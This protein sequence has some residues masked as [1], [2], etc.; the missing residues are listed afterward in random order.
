[1][2]GIQNALR[3][4]D[5]FFD[6]VI[7]MCVPILMK[8]LFNWLGNMEDVTSWRIWTWFS[9]NTECV[10]DERFISHSTTTN[11][12]GYRSTM[13]DEDTQNSI[14]LKAIK[15]YLDQVVRLDLTTAH[16]DL[17]PGTGE[18][19]HSD[20]CYYDSDDSEDDASYGSERTLAGQL[21]RYKVIKRLPMNEWYYIGN[22]A[23]GKVNLRI[24]QQHHKE[25]NDGSDNNNSNT[26]TKNVKSTT[27]HLFSDKR[28]SVDKFVD[29]AYR[30][31]LNELRKMDD[32]SRYYYDMQVP[33]IKIGKDKNDDSMERTTYKQ[34]KLSDEKSFESLFFREKKSLLE[35]VD[36][37][38]AKT[39]KYSIKGYPHKIGFLLY[40]PAGTGKTSLIKALAEYTGRSIVNVP[41]TRVT[42]NAELMSVFFDRRYNVQGSNVPVKL[43]FKDVIF[44]MEDCDAASKVVK[45]REGVMEADTSSFIS[46]CI[47]L[48][49]P[50]SLLR[51]FLESE[52]SECQDIVDILLSKSRRLKHEAETLRPQI[53]N[54]IARRLN[55]HGALG[56]ADEASSDPLIAQAYDDAIS[57]VGDR[58]EHH[59]KLDE[60]LVSHATAMKQILEA[61]VDVSEEFVDQLLGDQTTI[62]RSPAR[63]TFKNHP[64]TSES[65]QAKTTSDFPTALAGPIEKGVSSFF[66]P[67]PD[68]LSLSGLLNVLDGVVDTPGRM[69]VLTSNCPTMLD[70]ALI[71]PGRVDKQI[72]L[73]YMD[74]ENVVAMI[75]HF[76]QTALDGQQHDRVLSA[77]QGLK[78][79][80]AQVEQM[81]AEH[82]EVDDM[83]C[84]LEKMSGSLTSK[85]NTDKAD[86]Q[87]TYIDQRV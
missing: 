56:L 14:L 85:V 39:G 30:W 58:K 31:Y 23:G 21:S 17:T 69:V 53:L 62:V 26:S 43:D 83:I 73:G 22:F 41:L 81:A 67:N 57:T 74:S 10:V 70:P 25:G 50:K 18:S 38:R 78:L 54:N 76:F 47:S 60:I 11:Q 86:D 24:E 13:D 46:D 68:A 65:S 32:N 48:S 72:M 3:T 75:E 79:T 44:V 52:S 28:G 36:H 45:R 27:F 29:T 9:K 33:E 59:A 16:L 63:R 55:E 2:L 64:S 5:V 49:K 71:R 15:L 4:G 80:P 8:I 12:W 82:D 20:E 34:Y 61:N 35:L 51:L 77:A 66:K 1:M 6:M 7:A 19:S 84:V 42:T 87:Q 40:G 37:F